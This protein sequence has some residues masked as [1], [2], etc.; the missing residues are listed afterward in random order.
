MITSPACIICIVWISILQISYFSLLENSFIYF[1]TQSFWKT[2]RYAN[3]NHVYE[4]LLYKSRVDD[5]F[6]NQTN[7]RPHAR[8]RVFAVR[9]TVVTPIR[10]YIII[11]VDASESVVFKVRLGQVTILFVIVETDSD[12]SALRSYYKLLQHY[13][14]G[15]TRTGTTWTS[16]LIQTGL[17]F[18]TSFP[19]K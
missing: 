19:T 18:G 4:P 6:A 1:L 3:L 15:I 2:S 17:G 5:A 13:D 14:A 11:I 16:D 12:R 9:L 10:V 8:H 7:P